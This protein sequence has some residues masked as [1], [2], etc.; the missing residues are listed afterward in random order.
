M[1]EQP[2]LMDANIF[3]L[4]MQNGNGLMADGPGGQGGQ[5]TNSETSEGELM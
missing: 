2:S 4:R 5:K 1:R 3:L